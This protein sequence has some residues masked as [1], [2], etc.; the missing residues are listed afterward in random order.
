[1][2]R[3]YVAG[4]AIALIAIGS[5]F[6]WAEVLWNHPV[7]VAVFCAAVAAV[8]YGAAV[9]EIL[10]AE[11]LGTLVGFITM[12]PLRSFASKRFFVAVSSC[13]D[14]E[15]L[16]REALSIAGNKALDL[17]LRARLLSRLRETAPS[18]ERFRAVMYAISVRSNDKGVRTVI[19]CMLHP[20][21]EGLV[22]AAQTV[23]ELDQLRW[24]IDGHESVFMERFNELRGEYVGLNRL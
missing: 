7:F 12:G 5:F 15:K 3:P 14:F 9:W 22:R 17:S 24:L 21:V 6:F 18:P 11:E 10:F 4:F 2:F 13:D 1:M 19:S 8:Y 20:L 23:N 16:Y